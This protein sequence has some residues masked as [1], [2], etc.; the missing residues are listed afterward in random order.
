MEIGDPRFRRFYYYQ[1]Q[2]AQA[3]SKS[4]AQPSPIQ[5][6]GARHRHIAIPQPLFDYREK[7][8]TNGDGQRSGDADERGSGLNL[9]V[10]VRGGV[11]R[12]SCGIACFSEGSQSLTSTGSGL[13]FCHN[14][15]LVEILG[16]VFIN[17]PPHLEGIAARPHVLWE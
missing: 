10:A 16:G 2:K 8:F 6:Q 5:E 9:R 14:P 12:Y 1:I 11:F 7:S 15:S 4:S 17:Q 3:A 13:R